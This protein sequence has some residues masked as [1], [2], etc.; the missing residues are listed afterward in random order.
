MCNGH[1]DD[2]GAHYCSACGNWHKLPLD[3]NCTQIDVT[4]IGDISVEKAIEVMTNAV[5]LYPQAKLGRTA[6]IYVPVLLR[7]LRERNAS[8]G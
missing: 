6:R 3:E 2:T 7:A 4:K 1:C 5:D 8:D